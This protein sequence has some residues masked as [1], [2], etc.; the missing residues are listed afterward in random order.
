MSIW[1]WLSLGARQVRMKHCP[2]LPLNDW[3]TVNLKMSFLEQ[4]PTC[5][6]NQQ[7]RVH[8]VV[9]GLFAFKKLIPDFL[10]RDGRQRYRQL[11]SGAS[12]RVNATGRPIQYHREQNDRVSVVPAKFR[13][14]F[15]NCAERTQ[16]TVDN[17]SG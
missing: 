3:R 14:L 10:N 9:P 8:D 15:P 13:H 2:K 6:A 11:M 16:G 1:L 17:G 5:M 12:R 4:P 7:I